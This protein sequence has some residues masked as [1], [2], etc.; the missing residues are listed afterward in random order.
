[1]APKPIRP[2]CLADRT[3][4]PKPRSFRRTLIL[5]LRGKDRIALDLQHVLRPGEIGRRRLPGLARTPDLLEEALQPVRND[6]PDPF[7]VGLAFVDEHV[8]A[9]LA[10]EDR[11][12]GEERI[13]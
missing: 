10:E 11:R 5:R 12:S 3:I 1:M 2:T 8:A 13:I 4:M 6:Q 9:V 7:Q